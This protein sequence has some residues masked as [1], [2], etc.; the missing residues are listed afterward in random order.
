MTTKSKEVRKICTDVHMLREFFPEIPVIDD[1]LSDLVAE[2]L[3]V[4][5]VPAKVGELSEINKFSGRGLALYYR[6]RFMCDLGYVHRV[7]VYRGFSMIYFGKQNGS[8]S[9]AALRPSQVLAHAQCFTA[10]RGRIHRARAFMA[11][12]RDFSLRHCGLNSSGISALCDVDERTAR[13]WLSGESEPP[14]TARV[15]V[16]IF[17]AGNYER[18][19]FVKNW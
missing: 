8:I 6:G 3:A 12:F 7:H 10:D 13:R 1:G 14:F 5:G 9:P 16:G 18:P 11:S 2:S 4:F 17:A 15:V 19:Q